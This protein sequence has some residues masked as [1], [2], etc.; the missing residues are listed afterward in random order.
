MDELAEAKRFIR[1]TGDDQG[2]RNIVER[3][4]ALH[5]SI[6]PAVPP[7]FDYLAGRIALTVDEAAPALGISVRT[8][9]AAIKDGEIPSLMIKG[10]R[11][12]PLKALEHH[13]EALAYTSSGVLDVWETMLA[14]AAATRLQRARGEAFR[15]RKELRRRM[16]EARRAAADLKDSPGAAR[17]R[18]EAVV[19]QLAAARAQLTTEE[20]MATR[21]GEALLKDIEDLQREFR[22]TEEEVLDDG[23]GMVE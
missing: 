1:A 6:V 18:A 10:R 11:L 22:L 8:L 7:G 9:R 3:A 23:R 12:I 4:E 16:K 14:R 5:S 19:A 13:L 15:A 20:Q 2:P 17:E 21:M